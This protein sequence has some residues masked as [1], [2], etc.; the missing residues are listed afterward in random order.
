MPREKECTECGE[1][2]TG[3][4]RIK[5]GEP[6]CNGCEPLEPG[7]GLPTDGYDAPQTVEAYQ[8]SKHV[9][10]DVGALMDGDPR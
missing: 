7:K 3:N 8:R 6:Y 4:H 1:R 10:V 9:I 2:F 5:D